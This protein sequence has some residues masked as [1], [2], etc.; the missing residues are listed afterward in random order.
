MAPAGEPK[1]FRNDLLSRFA[2]QDHRVSAQTERARVRQ[3]DVLVDPGE[4]VRHVWFPEDCVVSLTITMHEGGS[5]EAA[6]IG[7]EGVVGMM[8]VLGGHRALS[9]AVVSIPGAAVRFPS[10]ELHAMFEASPRVRRLCLNYADALLSQV[11]QLS[12][13]SALHSLEARLCRWLLQL[14]DRTLSERALPLTHDFLAEMLGV[15]RTTITQAART[16][17]H[18]GVIAYRRGKVKVLDRALLERASCECYAAIRQHYER[19][20]SEDIH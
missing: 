16:L 6:T 17:Q 5:S 20:L 10:G 3:G 4:D 1:P 13:C 9:R 14:E 7:R 8:A 12:A 11:L 15:H 18:L 19:L 2:R